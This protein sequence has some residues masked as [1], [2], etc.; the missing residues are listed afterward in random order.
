MTTT[1]TTIGSTTDTATPPLER[2]TGAGFATATVQSARRTFLQY[3]RTPQLLVLPTII[4]AMFLFIFR[5]V[6]AARSTPG[7]ASTTSTSSSPGSC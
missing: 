3:L 5:Y 2:E 6:S 4:G 7:T 1:T